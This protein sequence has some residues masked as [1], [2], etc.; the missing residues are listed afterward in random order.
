[1]AHHHPS[2]LNSRKI[3]LWHK[4]GNGSTLVIMKKAEDITTFAYYQ[5]CL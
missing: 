2:R 5:E 3:I 4:E 1:M